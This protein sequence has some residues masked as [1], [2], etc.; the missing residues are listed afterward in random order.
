MT[1]EEYYNKGLELRKTLSLQSLGPALRL[2]NEG[3]IN[4]VNNIEGCAY[5]Q[6]S[7]ALFGETKPKQIVEL[8]GAMGVW[9]VCVLNNLPQDSK[10]YSVS[11]AEEGKEYS[12]VADK[13]PN[14]IPCVGDDLDLDV[15]P[16]ELDLHK[17][18]VWF[19]DTFH[20]EDQ[21]R[22]E[23]ALYSPFMKK[24]SL[25]LLDDIHI[26]VGMERVWNE[27]KEKYDHIDGTYP[28][29]WTGY[30]LIVI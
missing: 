16:K 11:L 17:T 7:S 15:W 12:Y 25:V 28:L 8:G 29:H 4:D 23:W 5:Y 24:G 21:L 14:F 20:T 3:A 19:I 18:D 26:N 9:D 22:K 2:C 27:L 13:Y 30:G 10:L 6:W 1:A